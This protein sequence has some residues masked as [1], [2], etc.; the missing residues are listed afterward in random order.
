MNAF[1]AIAGTQK[2]SEAQLKKDLQYNYILNEKRQAQDGAPSFAAPSSLGRGR[3]FIVSGVKVSAAEAAAAEATFEESSR[4]SQLPLIVP[5]KVPLR[6][7]ILLVH[8]CRRIT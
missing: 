8:S 6:C 1:D 4:A 5:P 3:T 7:L 2:K